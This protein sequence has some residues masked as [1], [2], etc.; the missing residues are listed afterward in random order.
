MLAQGLSRTLLSLDISGC[1]KV[2]S[3]DALI[4]FSNL[5]EL[6][7]SG[8]TFVSVLAHIEGVISLD[9]DNLKH[10][11]L[12]EK[13]NMSLTGKHTMYTMNVVAGLAHLKWLNLHGCQHLKED[14]LKVMA[15]DL[16][17]LTI[18]SR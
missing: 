16:P 10:L 4:S 14:H 1:K 13:L 11:K 17:S 8:M 15:R 9:F 7:I 18:F 2:G 5:K 3:G 6:N 12:L